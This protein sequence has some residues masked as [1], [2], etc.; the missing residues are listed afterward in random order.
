MSEARSRS[1]YPSPSCPSSR[2]SSSARSSEQCAGSRFASPRRKTSWR[3]SELRRA[4]SEGANRSGPRGAARSQP[5][6]SASTATL[7]HRSDR[8]GHQPSTTRVP[9]AKGGVF[10][11]QCSTIGF[12]CSAFT[13]PWS[14]VLRKR[15]KIKA[16]WRDPRPN[17]QTVPREKAMLKR[18]RFLYRQ[19]AC[20]SRAMRKV[21]T[22]NRPRVGD[23][24]HRPHIH[25]SFLS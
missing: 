10:L 24:R 19:R 9:Y 4:G 25:S 6:V 12:A 2:S 21:M 5:P 7:T 23:A 13:D 11:L 8:S 15:C 20:C 14:A 18:E 1:I 16:R 3:G 22:S 17:T